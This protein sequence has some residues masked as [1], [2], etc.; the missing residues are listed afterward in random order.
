MKRFSWFKFGIPG[1]EVTMFGWMMFKRKVFIMR[2]DETVVADTVDSV[3]M[4][5]GMVIIIVD[6]RD[7]FAYA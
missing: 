2:F 6:R 5:I 4:T 1:R 7:L 3:G